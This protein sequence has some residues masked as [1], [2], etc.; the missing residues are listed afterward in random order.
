MT[1]RNG[2][3]LIELLVVI[4]IIAILAAILFPVFIRA[5]DSAKSN[6]C[7][8]RQRQ[9]CMGLCTYADEN[10]GC[11]PWTSQSGT[12]RYFPSYPFSTTTTTISGELI[13]MLKQYVRDTR[14]F[15]CPAVD[16][17]SKTYSYDVQSQANPKFMYIG[18]YY[19]AGQ[20][21]G[22]PKP[23]K[24]ADNPRRILMSC[25]GGGV[26]SNDGK[27]GHGNAQ[28]VYTFADGH[29]KYIFHFNYPYSYGECQTAGKMH[30]LLMPKWNN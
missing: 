13:Y 3:T 24:Q 9:V 17:Y 26:V 11:F 22:G 12:Q 2:F 6:T 10:A 27:S 5:K 4:A 29:V 18:Y 30:M 20:A 15:Y 8:Q 1:K 7:L 14:M 25:I 16:A 23:I 19:Y 28:A 21:W